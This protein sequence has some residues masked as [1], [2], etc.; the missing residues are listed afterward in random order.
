MRAQRG[1][2]VDLFGDHAKPVR[3]EGRLPEPGFAG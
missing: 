2:F 3:L 1:G